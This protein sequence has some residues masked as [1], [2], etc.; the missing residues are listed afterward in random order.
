MNVLKDELTRVVV[1]RSYTATT[2][3]TIVVEI[4]ANATDDERVELIRKAAIASEG[5][6]L[7]V[8]RE[9]LAA[10]RDMS[11]IDDVRLGVS[12]YRSPR[13]GFV[14][15]SAK[16]TREEAFDMPRTADV[17]DY[18]WKQIGKHKWASEGAGLIRDDA[19][20]PTNLLDSSYWLPGDHMEPEA[21][22]PSTPGPEGHKGLFGARYRDILAAGTVH[23][24]GEHLCDAAS[25]WRDG[26]LIAVV[27]PTNPDPNN[28]MVDAFGEPVAYS[29]E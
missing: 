8:I 4:P 25:V 28:P 3:H 19:P 11:D 2:N 6:W 18:A 13:Q 5:D 26:E 9:E 7:A 10:G 12:Q 16:M 17:P 24:E 29:G 27:M 1:S 20:T 23:R 22:M 15:T 21:L 14:H